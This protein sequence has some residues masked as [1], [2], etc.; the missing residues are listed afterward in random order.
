MWGEMWHHWKRV[1]FAAGD[2]AA[3]WLQT[4]TFIL[5]DNASSN[6]ILYYTVGNDSRDPSFCASCDAGLILELVCNDLI[7]SIQCY[8]GEKVQ[9]SLTLQLCW[10]WWCCRCRWLLVSLT[11]PTKLGAWASRCHLDVY[12][13]VLQQ[14]IWIGNVEILFFTAS[15]IKTSSRCLHCRFT[16]R[17]LNRKCWRFFYWQ[18]WRPVIK[19]SSLR[20]L[21]HLE[22]SVVVAFVVFSPLY[23]SIMQHFVCVV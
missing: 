3:L 12:I 13:L 9:W 7:S 1:D 21:S 6:S 17:N 5:I 16:A 22:L 23:C 15:G 19:M 11:A 8:I 18:L 4:V 2:S 10:C 20:S 14:E